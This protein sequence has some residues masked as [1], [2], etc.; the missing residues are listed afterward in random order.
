MRTLPE[1]AFAR[2]AVHPDM[3][4]MKVDDFLQMYA[5]HGRHHTAHITELRKRMGW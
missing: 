5:W 2:T 4:L 1:P 3:G